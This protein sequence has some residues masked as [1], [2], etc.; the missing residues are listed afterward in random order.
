MQVYDAKGWGVDFVVELPTFPER[1]FNIVDYGAV[2]GGLIKNTEA[3][4]RA[5][6]ACAQAGGG[7]VVVPAGLW[8]TGPI[9]LQSNV[10][11]HLEQGAVV[12]FSPQFED[13]PLVRTSWEGKKRVCCQAPLNGVDLENVAITGQGIFDGAGQAWRMVKKE[14]LTMN[15]WRKLVASGGVV[16][17]ATKIWWPSKQAMNGAKIVTALEESGTA[18]LEDFAQAR[19]Y[20]RPVLLSLVRCKKVLLDGPTFRNSPSWNLHPLL[21]EDVTIRNI[22]AY[23]HW[24]A[25]NGDSLDLESCRR[26][27]VTDSFFNGGDDGI[28]LKSGKDREGRERGVPTEDVLIQNCVVYQGHGGFVVGSEMSGGVRNVYVRDCT[29][30]NTDIG[31]RFKSAR[32]RGGVVEKIY[33]ERINM[34]DIDKAAISISLFYEQKQRPK[35]D[36]VPPVTE[37]TP[38]IRDIHFKEVVCRGA[39]RAVVL[40]GLPEM[41]LSNITMEKV[42][43]SAQE[44]FFCSEVVDS[45]FKQ[46]EFF[47]QHGPVITLANTANVTIEVG[48][49]PEDQRLLRVEGKRSQGIR[50]IVPKGK[51]LRE[52]LEIGAEVPAEAIQ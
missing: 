2:P 39:E 18:T 51:E 6:S 47:P 28:C 35:Q 12:R 15:Q 5:M 50:I 1:T 4:A 45:S 38:A 20:L 22:T 19:E 8:L 16:D 26:V 3:F 10:N 34:L 29:F 13:Y 33:I 27:F 46:V 24:W 11:L 7:K 36:E 41:P 43:I 52:E 48:A 44:G 40:D 14:K 25:Q 30:I 42:S 21:C 31:L 23:N 49:Y 9:T 17:K 32:G 37:E